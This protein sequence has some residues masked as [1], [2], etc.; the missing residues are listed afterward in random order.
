MNLLQQID[1]AARDYNKSKDP[2]LKKKWYDLIKKF[3]ENYNSLYSKKATSL[4][5]YGV[6]KI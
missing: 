2:A 5:T 1:Q 3:N 4:H 6:R